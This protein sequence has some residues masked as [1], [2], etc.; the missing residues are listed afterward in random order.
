MSA[1]DR[2]HGELFARL[3]HL[4]SKVDEIGADVKSLLATRSF[5]AGMWKAVIGGVSFLV[6][7]LFGRN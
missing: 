3:D 4:E 7:L 1:H 2:E 5:A 6:G